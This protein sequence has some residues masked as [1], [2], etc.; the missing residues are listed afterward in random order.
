MPFASLGALRRSAHLS[1]VRET[2]GWYW[3]RR[4][5]RLRRLLECGGWSIHD[6]ITQPAVRAAI[7]EQ[8]RL[9]NCMEEA[10]Q[11]EAF[12]ARLEY[13]EAVAQGVLPRQARSR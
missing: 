4:A 3:E 7:R 2:P 12:I 10:R 11:V 9:S 13:L 1:P 6:L 8:W 5:W